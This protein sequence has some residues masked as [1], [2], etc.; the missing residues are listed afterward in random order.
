MTRALASVLVVALAGLAGCGFDGGEEGAQGAS[1]TPPE[2]SWVPG[3][4]AL[5]S[6]SEF[7]TVFDRALGLAADRRRARERALARIQK[8]KEAARKKADAEARRRYLEAKRRAERLYRLALKR[9]AEA[10]RRQEEK[11]R[12]LRA[13][14]R[15]ALAEREKKLRVA[16]G[17]ECRLKNVRERFDCRTGRLPD[18]ATDGKQNK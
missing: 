11:L 3:Q 10:R 12:R 18:P 4:P 5:G 16:P 15:R 13:E 6:Y 17:E 8:A 2:S 9:A 14:R 1:L 7:A